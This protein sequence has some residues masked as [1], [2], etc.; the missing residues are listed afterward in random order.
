MRAWMMVDGES[1][2]GMGMGMGM[3]LGQDFKIFS[4]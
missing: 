4:R 2:M 3:F 1:C